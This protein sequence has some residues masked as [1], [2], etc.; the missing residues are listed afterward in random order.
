M[1]DVFGLS[2]AEPA[3]HAIAAVVAAEVL[4]LILGKVGVRR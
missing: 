3:L 1:I 2:I 4:L